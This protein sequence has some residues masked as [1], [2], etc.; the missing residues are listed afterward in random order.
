MRA[1]ATSVLPT[2][3]SLVPSRGCVTGRCTTETCGMGV[4]AHGILGTKD[5]KM[6][7][8]YYVLPVLIG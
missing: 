1:G 6:T 2:A 4:E 5:M 7:N 3:V 8:T